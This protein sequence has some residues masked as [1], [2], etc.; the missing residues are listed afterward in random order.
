[1]NVGDVVGRGD[2][3]QEL[4]RHRQQLLEGYLSDFYALL[5]DEALKSSAVG[6]AP[7]R[8]EIERLGIRVAY[9]LSRQRGAEPRRRMSLVLKALVGLV[10]A[11]FIGFVLTKEG[12]ND[13]PVELVIGAGS[14]AV[15][16]TT[17]VMLIEAVIARSGFEAA[18]ERARAQQLVAMVAQLEEAA[19]AILYD[20]NYGMISSPIK[21]RIE[22]QHAGIWNSGDVVGYDRALRLRSRIVHGETGVPEDDLT[23]AIRSVQGQLEKLK[24]EAP[25]ATGQAQYERLLEAALSRALETLGGTGAVDA[26]QLTKDVGYDFVVTTEGK[27]VVVQAKYFHTSRRIGAAE[28]HRLGRG[29]GSAT[30]KMLI[31]SNV[32]LASPAASTL[33][34]LEVEFV[35]W[36]SKI[37]DAE[38]SKAISRALAG[39][40]MPDLSVEATVWPRVDVIQNGN[41][42][43]T[44]AKTY[45]LALRNTGNRPA[46]DV[47]FVFEADTGGSPWTVYGNSKSDEPDLAVLEPDSEARFPIVLTFGSASEVRCTVTWHDGDGEHETSALLRLA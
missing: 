18:A 35:Q 21:L 17:L 33:T 29:L 15:A 13:S 28:L 46:N 19:R 32:G 45:M 22:L 47:R 2:G 3:E 23:R 8:S 38:L 11:S 39:S 10:S 41:E 37:D 43:G 5:L 14:I 26:T 4:S 34:D 1:M 25:S 44:S 7:T 42:R 16:A 30:G 27:Q 20:R 31:V 12:W 36:R 9:R 40:S 24:L 6:K